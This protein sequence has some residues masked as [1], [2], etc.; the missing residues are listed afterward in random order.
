MLLPRVLTAIVG[1][2]LLLLLVHQGGAAFSLFVVGISTLCCYEYALVLRLGGRP[3]QFATTVVL[4]AALAACAALTAPLGLTLT[5]G[6]A[7]VALVEMFSAVHSLDRAAL[8]LFGALF[9]G[10]MPAHLAL[11]RD[12][13]P[14]GEAFLFMTFVSVWCMDTAAYAVG[15]SVGS[16]PLASVLSPKKTWEGALG[17]FAAALGV[18]A[19]FSRF[20]LHDA[21]PLPWALAA[22]AVIGVTGQVSD[23]AE[24]MVKRDAGVKDSGSLLPGH[25]GVLDRFDSFIL[26]APAVYYFLGCVPGPR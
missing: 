10:W 2:P 4:G 12:L 1:I 19:L 17:G 14:H 7:S 5:A 9:A 26:C 16:R 15:R 22:G 3:V 24:S 23:L 25:G 18:C 8:T 6:V 20:E 11:I 13:R 21:L